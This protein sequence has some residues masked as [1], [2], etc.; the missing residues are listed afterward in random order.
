M[1]ILSLCKTFS[2]NFSR[3]L[4]LTSSNEQRYSLAADTLDQ[5]GNKLFPELACLLAEGGCLTRLPAIA[6]V[7]SQS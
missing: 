6:G 5:I 7:R 3:N 2:I 1:S 4:Q